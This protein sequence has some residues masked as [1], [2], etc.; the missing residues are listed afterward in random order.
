MQTINQRLI[1]AVF[2]LIGLAGC[3]GGGEAGS[4]RVDEVT[5]PPPSAIGSTR[6]VEVG[7]SS[8]PSAT[9]PA[10]SASIM[11]ESSI[12]QTV[13]LAGIAKLSIPKGVIPDTGKQLVIEKTSLAE[14]QGLWDDTAMML[15]A[16]SRSQYEITITASVQPVGDSEA[17][18]T[19]PTDLKATLTSEHELRVFYVNRYTDDLGNGG[20]SIEVFGL[21]GGTADPSLTVKVPDYAFQQDASGKWVANLFV[22]S[23]KTA[24]KMATTAMWSLEHIWAGVHII[25]PAYAAGKVCKGTS[26]T[27]PVDDK[28]PISSPFGSRNLKNPPG[29]SKEHKGVDFPVPVGTP[30]MA[31]ADGVVEAVRTQV[32]RNTGAVTGWGQYV[33]LRHADGSATLYAHLT[34]GSPVT[35]GSQVKAGDNI[36]KSGNS[37]RSSGPHLHYEYAP[38][39]KI[40]DNS[41][42]VDPEPCLEKNA[43]G[44]LAVSDN[45]P[46]ADDSFSLSIDGTAICQTAIG[47]SNNCAIG[48]LRTGTY[49]LTITGLVVP[50]NEGTYG[51]SSASANLTINGQSSVSG[52]VSAGA[53]TSFT[54]VA[55][56]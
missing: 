28:F 1:S 13:E 9:V 7:T 17:E 26:L 22:G 45:G 20:D 24:A 30:V 35:Q 11:I 25:S 16:A 18:L 52:I 27:R 19:V 44:A 40:Y 54:L 2:V 31:A 51:I 29:A 36:A 5:S 50:D 15:Q 46:S 8:P 53:S 43:S 33:V 12:D 21:R 42:K 10:S 3:G 38:N 41:Q 23:T 49:I 39:G 47:Q 34:A 55:S 4:V 14:V 48:R 56:Q 32:D 6:A 37:G